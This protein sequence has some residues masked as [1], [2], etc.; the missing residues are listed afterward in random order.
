M[1]A[2][3]TQIIKY[4]TSLCKWIVDGDEGEYYADKH[5]LD[6]QS[7]GSCGAPLSLT[8]FLLLLDWVVSVDIYASPQIV[9]K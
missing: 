4:L 8:F 5:S 9:F 1:K 6:L 3:G 7:I 2:K